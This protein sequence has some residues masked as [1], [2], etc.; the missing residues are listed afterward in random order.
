MAVN[1][2]SLRSQGNQRPERILREIQSNLLECKVCFEMFNPAGQSE[3]RPQNLPCGHVLCLECIRALSHPVLK[4]LECP[5]CRQLCDVDS[6]SHC[7]ALSDLQELL[8]NSKVGAPSSGGK[9]CHVSGS[10]QLC[11]AFGGWGTLFNPTGIAVL[12]TS[13][14]MVVVH[15]G[16]T[17]VVVFGPQGRRLNSFGQ[18][19]DIGYPLDVA[20]TPSGHVVVTDAGNK[21]LKVFTS[22]GC[23]V[24]TL[25]DVFQLPWGVDIDSHGN[26][27]VSDSQTGTLSRVTLD[28][29]RGVILDHQTPITD[30]EHPRSVA[31]CQVTGATAVVEHLL[32]DESHPNGNH[33]PTRLRVYEKDFNLRYQIDS[34]S[35]SLG[36]TAW[37]CISAV[38]FDGDGN[39]IIIDCQ[40][41]MIW[42]LHKG[43]KLTPLIGENLVHPLGLICA[44]KD[45]TLTVLDSGD[46]TVKIYSAI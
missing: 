12:G 37:L 4:K 44:A 24:L 2:R 40:Q 11:S 6:T 31:C 46:H 23:H 14:T 25:T 8:L 35:L 30:L 3:H 17:R 15:D 33:R 29:G 39:V 13:G 38:A 9:A 34:F 1:P 28:C 10:L 43:T 27:L 18:R 21:S 32:F 22:R 26:I 16:D 36:S 20:V 42:K 45:N 5:F 7:Q 19:G 41:A